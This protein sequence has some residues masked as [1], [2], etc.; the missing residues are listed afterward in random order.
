[1]FWGSKHLAESEHHSLKL[2]PGYKP[3][4]IYFLWKLRRCCNIT[5]VFFQT[6]Y[7]VRFSLQQQKGKKNQLTR[8]HPDQKLWTLLGRLPK[9]HFP[10]FSSSSSPVL[11]FFIQAAPKKSWQQNFDGWIGRQEFWTNLGHPGYLGLF[12]SIWA[13]LGRYDTK[14]WSPNIALKIL[15]TTFL[16]RPLHHIVS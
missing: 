9:I 15:T 16:G 2:L 8:H 6:L 13:I 14:L 4:I 12:G 10:P 11:C 1:M 7:L 5:A 3:E